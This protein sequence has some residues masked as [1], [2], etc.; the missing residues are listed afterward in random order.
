MHLG[1]FRHVGP[2]VQPHT[3]SCALAHSKAGCV[4]GAYVQLKFCSDMYR[5]APSLAIA[6]LYRLLSIVLYCN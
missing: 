3:Q 5:A 4:A 1:L 6:F 2:S